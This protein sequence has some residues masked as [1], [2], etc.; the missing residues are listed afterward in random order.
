MYEFDRFDPGGCRESLEAYRAAF[1]GERIAV[2]AVN[3][4]TGKEL[5]LAA[6]ELGLRFGP[7][8]GLCTFDDWAIFPLSDVTAIRLQTEAV[9]EAAARMLLERIGSPLSADMA[10]RSMELEAK[11]IVRASTAK[12]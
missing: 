12:P 10:P 5:L 11:L 1:P 7:E 2:L 9:G 8:L 4:A 6:K 3:G